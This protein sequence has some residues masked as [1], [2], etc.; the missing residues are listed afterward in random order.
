MKNDRRRNRIRYHLSVENT[1]NNT[2]CMGCKRFVDINHFDICCSRAATADIFLTKKKLDR[3]IRRLYKEQH[4]NK[5]LVYKIIK[6]I[7]KDNVE[8]LKYKFI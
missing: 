4:E 5:D 3:A 2:W 6:F 8:V 7:N 1:E